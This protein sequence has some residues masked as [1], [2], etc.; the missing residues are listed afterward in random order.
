MPS[1]RELPAQ[2]KEDLVAFLAQLKGEPEGSGDSEEGGSA[3]GGG[4]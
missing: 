3:E 1:Y 4:P 2:K